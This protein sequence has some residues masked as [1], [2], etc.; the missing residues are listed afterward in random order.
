M[1]SLLTVWGVLN[2]PLGQIINIFS[3]CFPADS[4]RQHM[5]RHF[6]KAELLIQLAQ[7]IQ[8][9]TLVQGL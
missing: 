6:A 7:Q 2:L 5:N 8:T 1:S 9:I 3:E 4:Q